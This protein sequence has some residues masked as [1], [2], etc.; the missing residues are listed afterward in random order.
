MRLNALCE[1]A[2][3]LALIIPTILCLVLPPAAS[4]GTGQMVDSS[5]RLEV[6]DLGDRLRVEIR[7]E[8]RLNYGLSSSRTPASVTV[9]L[10]GLKMTSGFARKDVN[11]APLLEIIPQEMSKP[12]TGLKLVFRLAVPVKPVVHREGTRLILD[13]PK[14]RSVGR[15][16]APRARTDARLSRT[17]TLRPAAIKKDLRARGEA[18]VQRMTKPAKRMTKPAKRM[19]KIE[20]RRGKHEALVK[21]FGTGRLT[22]D[23]K[24]VDQSR[25]VVDLKNTSTALRQKV[26][27]V[28]HPLLKRVRLGQHSNQTRLVFDLPKPVSYDVRAGANYVAVRLTAVGTPARTPPDTEGSKEAAVSPPPLR[29]ARAKQVPVK[30]QPA[31]KKIAA[32]ARPSGSDP[33][34]RQASVTPHQPPSRVTPSKPVPVQV[35]PAPKTAVLPRPVSVSKPPQLVSVAPKKPRL[36]QIGSSFSSDPDEPPFRGRRISLDFQD[37]DITNVLRLIADVSNMNLVVGQKVNAKVT[38]KLVD[39]PWDQALE[40]ILKTNSLG[41][42]RED[43]IVW[44][45]T[46]ANIAKQQDAAAKAQESKLKA[47]PLVTKIIYIQNVDASDIKAT[48]TQHLSPRGRLQMN[49]GTNALVLQDTESTVAKFKKL[50]VKLDLPSPQVQIEGRIVQADTS[51]ARS[52]G[53]QWGFQNI[54]GDPASGRFAIVGNITGPFAQQTKAESLGETTTDFLVNLPA[55]VEGLG[56]IPA[57]GLNVGKWLGDSA[58]LDLRLSAGELLGLIK[59]LAAPKITT[60]DKQQA[61][62]EQGESIPFQTTSLQGTQTTFVDAN[63]ALEVTPQIT[64]RDPNERAKNILLKVKVTRNSVGE[65][66]NPAG[67]SIDKKEASTQVLVRDGETMVIGGIFLDEQRNTVGGVPYLSRIPVLGWLFKNKS[68]NVSKQ[69]LLIFLTPTIVS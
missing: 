17:G 45:D 30:A 57:I 42:V 23:V 21:I 2:A 49:A 55:A 50:V 18:P 46:L 68:E 61:K 32:P 60:L 20:V 22:Y 13:F 48:L 35:R 19:T 29:A 40:M 38:M 44:I 67:P 51:Y 24:L 43:N 5:G 4:G 69:E 65:R 34:S 26:L 56:S 9:T 28:D 15:T 63:L 3:G 58:S 37:A 10:P 8:R 64:S 39:I 14:A 41:M 66:S 31:P 27:P 7:G 54:N 62:I 16:R 59:T 6:L 1:K 12:G 33:G 47:E 53:V 52:V 25:L 11:K 36:A